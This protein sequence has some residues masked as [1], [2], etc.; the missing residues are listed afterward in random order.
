MPGEAQALRDAVHAYLAA[1]ERGDPEAVVA[2]FA[3]DA[4]VEDPVGTPLRLGL[5]AIREFYAASIATGAKLCLQGPIRA[6]APFAAFA[7]D[8]RLHHGGADLV[9]EVTDMFRFDEA[10]RISEMKAHLRFS[11][12]RGA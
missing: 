6:A 10:G 12:M 4:T 5:D 7:F 11:N 2:L 3:E 9:I 8:V 1:F